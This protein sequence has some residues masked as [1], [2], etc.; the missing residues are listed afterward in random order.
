MYSGFTAGLWS[1]AGEDVIVALLL[2]HDLYFDEYKILDAIIETALAPG[3]A[4]GTAD[5]TPGTPGRQGPE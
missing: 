1:V 2:N 5:S 3:T 4:R